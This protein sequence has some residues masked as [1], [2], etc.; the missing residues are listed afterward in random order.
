MYYAP[1]GLARECALHVASEIS[2][3][4]H[5][6]C[7]VHKRNSLICRVDFRKNS[8]AILHANCPTSNLTRVHN[9]AEHP[10]SCTIAHRTLANVSPDVIVSG[11][12]AKSLQRHLRHTA[13]QHVH[14]ALYCTRT[15][16]PVIEDGPTAHS[17][18]CAHYSH[19]LQWVTVTRNRYCPK[20]IT[21]GDNTL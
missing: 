10:G 11:A 2:L 18:E 6:H 21:P 1:D 4:E 12:C 20:H 19:C 7:V 3:Q 17:S 15:A 8:P 13:T 16:R 5:V 14:C 9:L